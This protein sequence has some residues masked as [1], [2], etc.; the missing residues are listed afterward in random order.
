MED[1]KANVAV[2]AGLNPEVVEK[3]DQILAGPND[4]AFM[5]CS[6]SDCKLNS[7]GHCTI[8]TI[9]DVPRMKTEKRCEGYQL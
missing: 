6:L 7:K 9:L 2:T 5:I 8:F 3:L 4:R 1:K